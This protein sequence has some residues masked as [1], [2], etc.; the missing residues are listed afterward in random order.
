MANEWTGYTSEKKINN[1]QFA[2]G[3]S[4]KII[5]NW[6]DYFM[7]KAHEDGYYNNEVQA[8]KVQFQNLEDDGILFARKYV[9]FLQLHI[10]I[11]WS[12]MI[13][14]ILKDVSK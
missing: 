10:Q 11:F 8:F 2:A 3:Q 7:N 6:T 5:V 9:I 14:N 12:S 4:T 1:K 13:V